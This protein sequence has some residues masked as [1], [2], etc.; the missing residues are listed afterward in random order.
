MRPYFLLVIILV[1]CNVFINQHNEIHPF[2]DQLPKVVNI[3]HAGGKGLGPENTM[4]TLHKAVKSGTDIIEI[5]IHYTSDSVLVLLHDKTVDRTT[6]G[7]GYVWDFNYKELKQLDAGFYWTDDD[8]LTFPYRNMGINIPSLQ[9][10]LDTF[11]S[12]RV[13]IE[14]KK[15]EPWLIRNFCNILKEYE[16]IDK[17]LIGSF[18]DEA[19]D[20]FRIECPEVATSAGRI[21]GMIFYRLNSLYLGWLY[22]PSIKVFEAPEYYKNTRV[23]NEQLVNGLHNKNI[24]IYVWTVNDKKDMEYLIKL[25]V[26]GIIT[27]Y[28]DRLS[29]ILYGPI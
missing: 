2:L 12:Y 10:V 5:D 1:G 29:E 18:I 17:V 28:P 8:S 23:I 11:S 25:G 24:P 14:I 26:D 9:E 3:A 22:T 15:Y 6:N 20:E 16:L 19:L 13:N 4:V 27:D 7:N 21:E